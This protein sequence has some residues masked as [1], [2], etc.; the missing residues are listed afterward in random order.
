MRA[1]ITF[2]AF[3]SL[4]KHREQKGF[5]DR[6]RHTNIHFSRTYKG[7]EKKQVSAISLTVQTDINYNGRVC[8]Y[9]E[10]RR[11]SET[12]LGTHDP[13]TAVQ[14]RTALKRLK[15][16]MEGKSQVTPRTL[17]FHP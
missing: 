17:H 2:P 13:R 10:G 4:G 7:R 12:P 5:K 11:K 16:I 6:H 14:L 1:N 9:I 3:L 15:E 8:V